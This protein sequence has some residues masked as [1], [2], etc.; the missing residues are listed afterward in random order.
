MTTTNRTIEL[1]ASEVALLAELLANLTANG[2]AFTCELRRTDQWD[3]R[4]L[5]TLVIS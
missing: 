3:T 1:A 5:I 2:V 4:W